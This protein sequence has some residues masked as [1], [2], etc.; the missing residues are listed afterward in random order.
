MGNLLHVESYYFI[1]WEI[2]YLIYLL[3][4]SYYF[5][6]VSERKEY[7]KRKLPSPMG[8]TDSG[9]YQGIHFA[10]GPAV[11]QASGKKIYLLSV[12]AFTA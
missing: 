2:F 1:A 8:N 12:A 10:P 7:W 6:C 3:N 9:S 4:G 5:L 11:Y